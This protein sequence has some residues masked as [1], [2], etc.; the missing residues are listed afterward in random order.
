MGYYL[1]VIRNL[2]AKPEE[3]HGVHEAPLPML[4]VTLFMA[5]LI[6]VFGVWPQPAIRVADMAAAGLVENVADYISAIFTP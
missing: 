5:V 4:V 6:I 2:L 1:I 3:D